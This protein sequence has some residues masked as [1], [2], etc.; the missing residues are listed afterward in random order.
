M[1]SR[2]R[3]GDSLSQSAVTSHVAGS[4]INLHFHFLRLTTANFR[5]MIQMPVLNGANER[6]EREMSRNQHG[7]VDTCFEEGQYEAGIA[8]LDQL[9]SPN[10]KPSA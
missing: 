7:I 9:R 8:T 1:G 4:S 6:V 5:V 2:R 10:Y 3:A